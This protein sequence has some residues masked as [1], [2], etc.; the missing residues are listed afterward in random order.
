MTCSPSDHGMVQDDE[1]MVGDI[2]SYWDLIG[3]GSKSFQ[4][5]VPR[6]GLAN[7]SDMSLAK[8]KSHLHM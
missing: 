2:A 6:S 8:L 1:V 5:Y 4:K 7:N 3:G